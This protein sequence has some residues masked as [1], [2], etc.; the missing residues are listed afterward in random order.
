MKKTDGILRKYPL[1]KQIRSNSQIYILL[2]PAF[3]FMAV[4]LYY[5]FF[6]GIIMSVQDFN[7]GNNPTFAG[8]KHYKH[9]LGDKFFWRAFANTLKFGGGSLLV[10]FVCQ[11]ALAILLN[12]LARPLL[13]RVTQVITYLPELFSWVAVA[14]LWINLL[15]PNTGFVNTILIAMGQ[16]SVP[17][18]TSSK[19]IIPVLIFLSAWKT[20]GYGCIIFLAAIIS[21]DQTLYEAARVDGASR[22]QQITRIMI[23]SIS[24]TM[25]AVFLLNLIAALR[26]FDQPYILGNPAIIDTVD[27]IMTYTYRIG[28]QDFRFDYASAVAVLIVIITAVLLI[29]R[30]IVTKGG[31][32]DELEII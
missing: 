15:A 19:W 22:Y 21:V 23:P 31:E 1:L 3:L 29:V 2:V 8:L 9:I 27:T 11:L 6:K 26:I 16:N 7:M 30:N 18:L 17:F 20:T 4:F 24:T 25:K 13:R 12:E 28:I 10:C 5:P 32:G 14:G